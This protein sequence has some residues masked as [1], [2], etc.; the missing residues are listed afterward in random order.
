MTDVLTELLR[1]IDKRIAKVAVVGQGYVGLPLAL[2]A[3]EIGFPVVGYEVDAG[4][5]VA[6]RAGR[7]HV[8]D[9]TNVELAAALGAGYRPTADPLDMRAFDVAIGRSPTP[10]R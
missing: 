7:S 1:R 5:V 9:V 2:R 3:T 10:L 8:E 6:L 4:R